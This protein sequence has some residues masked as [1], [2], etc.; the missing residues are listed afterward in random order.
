MLVAA[1]MVLGVAAIALGAQQGGEDRLQA[2]KVL[3]EAGKYQETVA[4]ARTFLA[5]VRD[6]F[7][8]TEA[9]RLLAV[10]LRKQGEW[11][12][13]AKAYADLKD[14]FE[15]GS[16]ECVEYEAT[17]EVLQASPKGIYP[18][19][20]GK[21]AADGTSASPPT[22]ADDRV[23]KD[24]LAAV[25]RARAQKLNVRLAAA[26]KSTSAP[27]I[28]AIFAEVIDGYKA[29]RVLAPDFAPNA[30]R[31]AAETINEVLDRL[32]REGSANLR[33]KINEL[34]QTITARHTIDNVQ[35]KT[36][37]DYQDICTKMAEAEASFQATLDKIVAQGWADGAR[38]KRESARRARAYGQLGR[39]CE[40]LQAVDWGNRGRRR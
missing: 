31:E 19:L 34:E 10:S 16:A 5:G 39:R 14:R 15:K 33:D 9:M 28:V 29:V 13:A 2:M 17:A 30:E 36:L 12:A 32:E 6:E 8:R 4:A 23:L 37:A 27:E 7:A 18:P 35:H 3:L 11:Q 22:L 24:A 25:G 20:A 38:L 1:A 26:K 40:R 21:P